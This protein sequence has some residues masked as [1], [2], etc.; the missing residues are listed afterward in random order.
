M[1]ESFF[2][3]IQVALGTRDGLSRVP[4]AREWEAMYDEAWKQSVAGICFAGIKRLP[5]A[6]Q[7][8]E[9]M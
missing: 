6:Q 1:R 4:S 9:E 5:E 2:E 8:L 3:L 7:P